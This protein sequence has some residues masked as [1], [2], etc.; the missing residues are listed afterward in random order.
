MFGGI[1]APDNEYLTPHDWDNNIRE[2][3]VRYILSLFMN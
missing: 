1:D 2:K 3:T